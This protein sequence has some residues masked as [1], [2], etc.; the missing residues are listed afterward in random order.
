MGNR[1]KVIGFVLSAVALP[2]ALVAQESIEGWLYSRAGVAVY[3][4]DD[5]SPAPAPPSGKCET[6]NGTGRVGDG[7]VSVA[8]MDCGGDGVRGNANSCNCGEQ[9]TCGA[10]CQCVDCECC[11]L[12]EQPKMVQAVVGYRRICTPSGCVNEP[13]T[14]W[15]P[16][17]A[18]SDTSADP[19]CIDG[20][21][22]SAS[23]AAVSERSAESCGDGGPVRRVVG[24]L[25]ENKPVRSLVGR[26]IRR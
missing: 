11:T 12:E 25:R 22:A 3:Q 23:G 17:V 21:C 13:I 16:Y 15:V 9:C 4:S 19:V 18:G 10:D 2:G 26:L 6:C 8:C 24:R 20:N 7:R 1:G 5:A 14:E